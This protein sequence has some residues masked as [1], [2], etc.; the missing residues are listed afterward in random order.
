MTKIQPRRNVVTLY[1][2][3]YEQEL[4]DLLEDT[5]KAQRL[6]TLS[7]SK[8]AGTKSAAIALAKKYDDHLAKAEDDCVKVDV[9]A[10][11]YTQWGP[12]ADQFPPRDDEAD[13]KQRGVNMKT[14]P[15]ALL[16]ASLV[17]PGEVDGSDPEHIEAL[18]AKGR[19]AL[20]ELGA[21]SQLQ[22]VKLERAA[23]NVNVGDDSLPKF[24]LVSLLKQQRDPDS[25]PL[26]EQG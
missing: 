4:Q 19:A 26:S 15:K 10:L 12:L 18:Q 2:G 1:Q 6:E 14:F 20:N 9:W 11:P 24:S 22:Y 7:G 21:L 23:W 16:C 3:N 13:D 8:R 17:A 5:E 25:K